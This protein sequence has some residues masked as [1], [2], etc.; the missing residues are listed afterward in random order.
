MLAV[1]AFGIYD[2][3]VTLSVDHG[4]SRS[5]IRLF[6][7]FVL[8]LLGA[9]MAMHVLL[10]DLH[11]HDHDEQAMVLTS[12]DHHGDHGHPIV[13]SS[14]PQPN[15]SRSHLP[16][17]T[18]PPSAPRHWIRTSNDLRN[19]IA[20]GAIRSTDDDVGLHALFSTYLI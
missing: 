9:P 20:H 7:F 11:G 3:A 5:T 19:V 17:T 14:S 2:S 12:D 8:A 16:V 1:A 6:A 18:A 13:S 15:A 4:M 10:H